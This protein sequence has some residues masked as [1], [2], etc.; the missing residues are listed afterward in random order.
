MNTIERIKF[1]IDYFN[2]KNNIFMNIKI[3]D[4]TVIKLNIVQLY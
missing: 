4:L 1:F 2:N 3:M